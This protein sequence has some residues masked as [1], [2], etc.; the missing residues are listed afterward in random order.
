MM[1]TQ[2]FSLMLSAAI[3]TTNPLFGMEKE[4]NPENKGII[5][6]FTKINEIEG[7]GDFY[8]LENEMTIGIISDYLVPDNISIRSATLPHM[9]KL[10]LTSKTMYNLLQSNELWNAIVKTH[11]ILI[12]NYNKLF[13]KDQV[14]EHLDRLYYNNLFKDKTKSYVVKISELQ[15]IKKLNTCYHHENDLEYDPVD[16]YDRYNFLIEKSLFT[17]MI[18]DRGSLVLD[19]LPPTSYTIFRHPTNSVGFGTT[20]KKTSLL[21]VPKT[22]NLGPQPKAIEFK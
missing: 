19:T 22:M 7:K 14:L 17:L 18:A 15:N 10:S 21:I 3:F 2:I 16:S 11:N 13:I 12:N 9:L 8:N 4:D 20:L 1:K 5:R 6:C